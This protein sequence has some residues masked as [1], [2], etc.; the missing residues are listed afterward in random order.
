MTTDHDLIARACRL[1]D[2]LTDFRHPK[3]TSA[4]IRGMRFSLD[5]PALH[6]LLVW[7]LAKR[8]RVEIYLEEGEGAEVMM[9][10]RGVSNHY[11]HLDKVGCIRVLVNALENDNG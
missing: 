11:F 5:H 3:P 4:V 2:V 8:T 9:Y 7:K 10:R 1:A 6:A